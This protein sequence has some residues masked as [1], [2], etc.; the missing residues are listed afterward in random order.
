MERKDLVG[1]KRDNVDRV[2]INLYYTNP[3]STDTGRFPGC[4]DRKEKGVCLKIAS[5]SNTHGGGL[6]LEQNQECFSLSGCPLNHTL[7]WG[8]AVTFIPKIMFWV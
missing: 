1:I 5:T 6:A 2:K 8:R 7:E 3:S 4:I